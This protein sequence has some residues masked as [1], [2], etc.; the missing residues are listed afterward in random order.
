MIAALIGVFWCLSLLL[1]VALC[2]AARRGD[3]Q[4]CVVLERKQ[5]ASPRV[6][7]VSP[8]PQVGLAE[9]GRSQAH[10]DFVAQVGRSQ[11]HADLAL[12]SG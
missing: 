12:E 6:P 11:A 5:A 7:G 2:A 1:T 8:D 4:G 3:A 10:A 9:V